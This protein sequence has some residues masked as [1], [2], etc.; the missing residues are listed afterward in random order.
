MLVKEELQSHATFYLIFV[1][2][3]D[4]MEMLMQYADLGRKEEHL[5]DGKCQSHKGSKCFLFKVII[6]QNL[7]FAL[8]SNLSKNIN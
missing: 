5:N 2:V 1:V 7:F 6:C 8:A 4:T 3:C